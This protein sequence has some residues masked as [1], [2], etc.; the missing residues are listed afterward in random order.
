MK[1]MRGDK[2]H[3]HIYDAYLVF[4]DSLS[5][6]N[7]KALQV[8]PRG[9]PVP[10]ESPKSP[11]GHLFASR[12]A[13]S[14]QVRASPPPAVSRG[15]ELTTFMKTHLIMRFLL[16]PLKPICS[17][18]LKETLIVWSQF[19]YSGCFKVTFSACFSSLKSYHF[20]Q[21]LCLSSWFP[22]FLLLWM[23]GLGWSVG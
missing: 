19:I 13:W 1:L 9:L 4:L 10:G 15:R 17:F 18:S 2:I 7:S 20:F 6:K 22:C 23:G 8:S 14:R 16:L 11:P 3:M 12:Q 21:V 5:F